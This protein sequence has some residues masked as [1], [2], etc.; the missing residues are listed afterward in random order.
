MTPLRVTR[1]HPATPQILVAEDDST[2]SALVECYLRK[3]GY[4]TEA[5]RTAEEAFGR[6]EARPPDLALIDLHLPGQ[7][8]HWLLHAL[9]EREETRMLPALMVSGDCTRD[10]RFRALAAGATDF[11]LKPYDPEEMVARIRALVAFKVHCDRLDDA[12]CVMV[13]IANTIDARDHYT[14]G[15]S[16]RVSMYATRLARQLRL[17]SD[18]VDAVRCGG[19]IHDIGKL[20]VRDA[21]LLKCAALDE[22]ERRE[23]ERHPIEGVRMIESLR[24]LEHALPVVLHHHERMDGSGYPDRLQGDEIPMIA[25]VTSIA[26]VFDSLTTPRPYRAAF[27]RSEALGIMWHEA[28]RGWWDARLLAVFEGLMSRGPITMTADSEL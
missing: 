3:C 28:G 4:A 1:S 27:H 5:V 13:M 18:E 15:H 7:G 12:E 19:L 23:V 8:G 25:R 14:A 26:D 24:S 11:L 6:I 20:V 17:S 9:R 22:A 21:I 16:A 2:Q 10:D